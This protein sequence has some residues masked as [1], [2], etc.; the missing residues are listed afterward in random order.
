MKHTTLFATIIAAS[1]STMAFSAGSDSSDPPKPT[2]TTA[3]CPEGFV[4]VPEDNVC[5]KPKETNF[6]DD[7]IQMLVRNTEQFGCG[8]VMIGG[9]TS[10]GAI[11]AWWTP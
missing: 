1:F 9:P 4:Y 7:Q 10:F 11:R 2:E 8:L 6:T 5:R 3:K